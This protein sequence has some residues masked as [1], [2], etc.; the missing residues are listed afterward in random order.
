MI[1]RSLRLLA[2]SLI[3]PFLATAT[4]HAQSAPPIT[5]PPTGSEIVTCVQSGVPKSCTTAQIAGLAGPVGTASANT[6]LAGPTSGSPASATYRSIVA[7]DLLPIDLSSTANGGIKNTLGVSHGG[8]GTTTSTGSGSLVLSTSPTLVT[9]SLGTPSA[10]TLTNATSLPIST[11]VSGL[12]TSVATALGT[13]VGTTGSV[14]VNG[15]ALG[16][17]SSGIATNLTGTA[18]GLTAGNVTTNANLTGPITSVGNATSVASQ[19]GTGSTFVMSTSPTL[20]T[21]NLG[22]PSAGVLTNATGL[23]LT[24]GVT[25]ILPVANGGSGIATGS[26]NLFFGTPNGSSG[27]PS[28][29]ALT[30]TDLPNFQNTGTGS[31]ARTINSKLSDIV[32]AK[33]FGAVCNGTTDD[34]AAI[35]AALTYAATLNSGVVMLPASSSLCKV[36]SVLTVGA[37]VTLRGQ[38]WNSSSGLTAGT[39]GINPLINLTGL[40]SS[41]QDVAITANGAGAA[42]GTMIKVSSTAQQSLVRNIYVVGSCKALSINGSLHRIENFYALN[43]AGS[44]CNVV[45]IGEDTTAAGTVDVKLDHVVVTSVNTASRPDNCFVIYDAGGL[46]ITHSDAIYCN[47]GTTIQPG[48]NQ[49]VIWFTGH[50]TYLGDSNP[51]AG[52]SINTG[53]ASSVVRGINCTSCW[54]SNSSGSGVTISNS[55][56]GTVS[57]LNFVA[58]RGVSNAGNGFTLNTGTVRIA[59]SWLCGTGNSGILAASGVSQVRV[60]NTTIRPDCMGVSSSQQYGILFSGSNADWIINALDLTGSAVA[61]IGGTPTGNSYVTEIAT[62]GNDYLAIA[63]AATIALSQVT[64]YWKITGTTGVSTINNY[65]NGRQVNLVTTGGAVSFSTGGNICNAVTST[66]NVPIIA[67][68]SAG[69]ACWYL[70]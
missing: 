62:Q 68:Y 15:G 33:D 29:R 45:T 53:A 65:W 46:F 9:P 32:N 59:D 25:G 34:A 26:A 1:A 22:T 10:I 60:S 39:T 28:F 12:G 37:G 42:T 27:A 31:V 7:A 35:N 51:G 54:A 14:V 13:N 67:T 30:L 52:V 17:P 50:D 18:S 4:V 64:P 21:P 41:V 66:Q 38:G 36:S 8:S 24:T 56:A 19:T 3:L 44:G 2:A 43:S 20:V 57:G 69:S 48:A 58:F 70:K 47:V 16:T 49:Q 6:V 63:S 40:G 5:P 11:G 61:G 23:P 55:G